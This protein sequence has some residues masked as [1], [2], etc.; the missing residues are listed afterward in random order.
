MR[1]RGWYTY[2]NWGSFAHRIRRWRG[3]RG[4]RGI[5]TSV[6]HRY[7]TRGGEEESGRR[8]ARAVSNTAGNRAKNGGRESSSATS[9]GGIGGGSGLIVVEGNTQKEVHCGLLYPGTRNFV[10]C[11][12]RAEAKVDG[13]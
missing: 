1:R 2:A 10:L 4:T 11:L 7:E 6:C 5:T 8:G 12:F 9:Y 13:P 3:W